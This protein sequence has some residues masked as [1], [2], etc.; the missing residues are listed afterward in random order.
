VVT[1]ASGTGASCPKPSARKKASQRK[2]RY[3]GNKERGERRPCLGVV[4]HEVMYDQ[5]ATG[6]V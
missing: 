1:S 6:R 4:E 2:V 3:C 5:Q